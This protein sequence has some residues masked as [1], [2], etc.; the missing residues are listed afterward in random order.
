[1]DKR[2][3]LGPVIFSDKDLFDILFFSAT[4]DWW[5]GSFG[6]GHRQRTGSTWDMTA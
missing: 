1:M 4:C 3:L 2:N 5:G 6:L